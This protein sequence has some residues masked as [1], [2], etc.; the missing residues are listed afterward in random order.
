MNSPLY[1]DHLATTLNRL[2]KWVTDFSLADIEQIQTLCA[3][4]DYEAAKRIIKPEVERQMGDL[5]NS[6]LM[7]SFV[8]RSYR[9][10]WE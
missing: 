9:E 7:F 4:G 8:P 2:Q 6:D 10:L 1:S 3:S 5:L